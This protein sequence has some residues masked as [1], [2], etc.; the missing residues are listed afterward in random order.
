V[1]NIYKR[2]TNTNPTEV[3]VKLP[4]RDEGEEFALV[5]VMTGAEYIKVLCEDGLERPARI[6]GKLRNRVFI[7]DNDVLIVKKRDY[8][9]NKVD[10]VWRFLPFQRD[11]LKSMGQLNN[12]P[13]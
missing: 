5:T 9:E 7:K 3:R 4:N 12:L 10:V 2:P 13:I 1:S 6:P 8:E 11:K